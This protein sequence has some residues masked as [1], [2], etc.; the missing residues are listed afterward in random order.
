[1]ATTIGAQ[2]NDII[3]MSFTFFI[4]GFGGLEFV[5]GLMLV[6]LMKNLNVNLESEYLR[7]NESTSSHEFIGSLTSKKW[8]I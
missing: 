3:S 8:N 5:I 7:K 4:L 6:V 2:I 1:M